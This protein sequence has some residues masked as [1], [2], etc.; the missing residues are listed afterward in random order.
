MCLL[1]EAGISPRDFA[2]IRRTVPRFRSEWCTMVY[3][4][5]CQI[6]FSPLSGF[7]S[8]RFSSPPPRSWIRSASIRWVIG[9]LSGMVLFPSG[10]QFVGTVFFSLSSFFLFCSSIADIFS[11]SSS[12]I[13]VRFEKERENGAII[14]LLIVKTVF[15][16]LVSVLV[17]KRGNS[18]WTG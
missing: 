9:L 6:T 2:R 8:P 10:I 16:S 5:I 17:Q 14:R 11:S 18:D 13:F 4:L 3:I 15:R 12:C 7:S 1:K